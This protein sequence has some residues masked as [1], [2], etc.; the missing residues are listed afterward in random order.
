MEALSKLPDYYVSVFC[1]VSTHN[2]LPQ[3]RDRLILIGSKNNF[4][5]KEPE[6][7][8]RIRLKDIIEVYPKISIPRYVYNRMDQNGKYRDLPI[9]S[10]PAN[11]DI[12]PT[13]VAHYSKDKSTRLLR[14]RNY[15]RGVRPYTTRKYAR[16][17]GVPDWFQF[18]GSESQ[19]YK[20]IGNGVPTVFGEWIG[21]EIKRYFN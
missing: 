8:N 18:C 1:P 15:P 2:F 16:L 10:D 14:D 13:C 20:Q 11:D 3:K 5:W 12:A 6:A 4:I 21:N 7:R 17:Q 9:I 19:I